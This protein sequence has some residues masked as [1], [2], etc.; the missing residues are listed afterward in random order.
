MHSSTLHKRNTLELYLIVIFATLPAAC[1]SVYSCLVKYN[2]MFP[3]N[4]KLFVV[5][6]LPPLYLY[7]KSS[8]ASSADAFD[9]EYAYNAYPFA[10]TAAPAAAPAAHC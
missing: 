5:P 6:Y 3:H 2:F 4:T 10:L 7:I 9:S 8:V 1:V